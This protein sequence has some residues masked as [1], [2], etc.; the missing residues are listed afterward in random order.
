MAIVTKIT[1]KEPISVI[2]INSKYST[3]LIQNAT[4][5]ATHL[6][7]YNLRNSKTERRLFLKDVGSYSSKYFT[8]ANG[9]SLDT[10]SDF[11]TER[12]NDSL[13]TSKKNYTGQF[14]RCRYST[15]KTLK[16][17]EIYYVE[18]QRTNHNSNNRWS[19]TKFKIRGIRNL[20]SPYRFAEIDIREQRNIKL[21][22]LNGDKV[23]T[24]EQT[25]K[26]LLYTEKEKISILF[27]TLTKA[28]VDINKTQ[29]TV[30]IDITK[31]MIAKG[32][33]YN[34]QEEDIKPFLKSRID[35]MLKS[36][37]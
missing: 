16:Q 14:V 37:K 34:L 30:S 9:S 29:S 4:Y 22:N 27:E 2:C 31:L 15:G 25:R 11:D 17:N 5:Q 1:L 26:F 21:K 3:K 10:I 18:E 12:N 7:T 32:R 36:F 23:K 24:G 13:D 6:H 28:I 20:V 33:N 8:L 35:T 19:N